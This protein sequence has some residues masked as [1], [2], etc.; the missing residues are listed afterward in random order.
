M[1]KFVSLVVS[2]LLVSSNAQNPGECDIKC[3]DL[4][5]EVLTLE[6]CR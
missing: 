4:R 3:N 1:L 2:I 6:M 5:Y